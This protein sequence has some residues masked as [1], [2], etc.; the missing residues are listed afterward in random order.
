[1]KAKLIIVIISCLFT[2][3]ELQAQL[4]SAPSSSTA[5]APKP[6]PKPKPKPN[7]K[8]K[9][10]VFDETGSFYDG[11]ARVKKN[12]K[13]GYID[14]NNKLI[15]PLQ[16][17]DLATV[18]FEGLIW[19]AVNG[20]YGH[21][22]TK[23]VIVT[24]FR[25][26][27]SWSFGDGLAKVKLN[28]LYG[29]V[30]KLG[31]EVIYPKYET[32][33][34]FYNGKSKVKLNGEEFYI[35]KFGSRIND[36]YGNTT[37]GTLNISDDFSSNTNNWP[38]KNDGDQ[39]MAVRYGKL[40][41]TGNT[42]GYSYTSLKNYNTSASAD[43]TVSASAKWIR[44]V[45]D[46]GFGIDFGSDD[47]AQSY[48][49]FELSANGYYHFTTMKNN[50]QWTEVIE[51]TASSYI[52]KTL[53]NILKIKKEGS[54]LSF[55]INDHYVDSKTISGTFGSDFGF[56]V[57][58]GQTVEF[59]NFKLTSNTSGGT[60]TNNNVANYSLADDFSS[61]SNN[62]PV[63]YDNNKEVKL[64]YGKLSIRGISADY[65]YHSLL[66]FGI[67]PKK[68]FNC[69]VS[70]RWV[71]GV[72][73]RSYGLSFCAD[74]ANNNYYSFFISGNGYYKIA[75][76][77]NGTWTDMK[78]WTSS[79]M[80]YKN[81]TNILAVK[82]EGTSLRFYINDVVVDTETF[83]GAFGSDF[84]VSAENKQT[85]EFDDFSIQ[86]TR[87]SGTTSYNNNNNSNSFSFSDYFSNNNSNWELFSDENK[88]MRIENGKLTIAGLG[89]YSFTTSKEF[90]VNVYNDFTISIDVKWISGIQDGS[91]GLNYA[92]D[93]TN[94][95]YYTFAI[96]GDGSYIINSFENNT[97]TPVK[98]WTGSS[99]IRKNS[100]TNN[101][102]VKRSGSATM[103][104][105]NDNL[106]ETLYSVKSYGS[107]FGCRV[108]RVQT[109]EF[110]NFLLEGK[111][112]N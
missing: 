50:G 4:I 42:V 107:A 12:G 97:W 56:K 105:I 94:G 91:L 80:I 39:S 45:D 98:D 29:F 13:Y 99:Y 7:P 85:I 14:D 90:D 17:S 86:G 79:N 75:Y 20:K 46:R 103:Y 66:N 1:M 18:Q 96:S 19:A 51:W 28:G 44:G 70:T 72:D 15:I 16:Y 52:N 62:W 41:I 101:L 47:V 95:K 33:E 53:E 59:D 73:D 63:V 27:D 81:S 64:Q 26:D 9:P 8:V 3:G 22:N 100:Q 40:S 5:S 110:D 25:Y 34:S 78:A 43:F 93:I 69:S 2:Y 58:G 35:D 112:K 48:Y 11:M 77:K 111:R 23:G 102:K 61:N 21:I 57:G 109:V 68:D 24:P 55:Y 89:N 65:S 54:N 10:I 83:P 71:S 37:S 76:L 36:G 92:S 38:L 106:V 30:N 104:Y 60:V 88:T 31:R 108:S 6:K 87:S 84:G 49:L 74:F 67:D 32:V 82:K